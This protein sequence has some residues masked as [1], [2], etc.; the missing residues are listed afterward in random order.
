MINSQRRNVPWQWQL[1]FK[2]FLISSL[3]VLS[4]VD[5][6]VAIYTKTVYPVEYYTPIVKILTFVSILLF[7]YY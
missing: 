7:I 4:C 5:L 6:G 3:V 2:C 1:I